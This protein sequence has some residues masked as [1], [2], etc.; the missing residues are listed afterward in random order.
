MPSKS[1]AQQRFFYAVKRAKHDPSYGDEKLHKV[2]GSMTDKDIDDFTKRIAELRVKKA[3]LG[4]LKDI[5]D[6]MYLDE[7]DEKDAHMEPVADKIEIK[8]QDWAS[9]I[10]K[11]VGQPLSP[12][13]LEAVNTFKSQSG[14]SPSGSTT[15]RV[16]ELWYRGSN[17]MNQ[18]YTVVIKKLK[19]GNQFSYNA[20]MRYD[21][22]QPEKPEEPP[23]PEPTAP[24]LS[25]GPT[26]PTP[27]QP[28]QEEEKDYTILLIKSILFTDEIKGGAILAEF[29]K[30]LELW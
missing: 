13:E 5:R 30:K 9:Y 4:I 3:V 17:E 29:L 8:D 22:Q 16:T 23:I 6:P 25:G 28:E 10:K 1:S 15:G 18:S 12:K 20:F 26:P 11:Y 14:K 24:D 2:A 21:K 7:V 27:E 19:D